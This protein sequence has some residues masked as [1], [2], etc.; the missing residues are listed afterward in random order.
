MGMLRVEELVTGQ[1]CEHK[2]HDQCFPEETLEGEY[3][4][5]VTQEKQD[6][7]RS[8]PGLLSTTIC[9]CEVTPRALNVDK[10]GRL[11]LE[12]V[13][14]LYNILQ[15]RKRKRV[16]KVPV[17]QTVPIPVIVPDVVDEMTFLSAAMDNT[18]P[19]VEKYLADGGDP[20]ISDN[21]NRTALHKASSQ[22]HVEI[23]QKL[24]EAGASIES[25]DKLDSTAVHWAC[26]GGSLPV[27]E[28]L[29][30]H[31]ASLSAR[32]KLRSTPLHVAVRTGRHECAQHLVH[33][34][35][36]IN[37]KDG[38]GDTPMHEAVRTNRFKIIQLLLISGA[39]VTLR[40]FE[41]KTPME[42]LL[43]WQSGAKNILCNY[44]EE[45]H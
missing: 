19:V 12:T 11:K 9:D 21:F 39:N 15:L 22:G 42:N 3:E 23:V 38:E 14:D 27:L 33:C 45:N 25:K 8:H 29:L 24:L 4:T 16:R 34:G 37:S 28:L 41:G 20:N 30:N 1:K 32:D 2:E 6:D 26:R 7:L 44:K 43:Q 36:D 13:D 31:N 40:N 35:A 17:Q 5:A 10:A 18:L